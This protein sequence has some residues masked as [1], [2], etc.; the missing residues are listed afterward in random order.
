MEIQNIKEMEYRKEKKK[1]FGW[2]AIATIG[3]PSC[4]S[5][6]LGPL[7]PP[8]LP[9]TP[10]LPQ[11]LAASSLHPRASPRRPQP[12]WRAQWP[13]TPCPRGCCPRGPN[14]WGP[15]VSVS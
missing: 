5:P 6:L 12:T 1:E 4:T 2:A 14:E 7:R 8:P 15:H 9:C 10:R 3:P 11:T 13:A